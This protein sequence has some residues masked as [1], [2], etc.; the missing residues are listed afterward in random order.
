LKS[1]TGSGFTGAHAD[2]IAGLP[3]KTLF[4]LYIPADLA[5]LF[6]KILMKGGRL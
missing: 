4:M 3:E 2:K 1:V 6:V 5:F